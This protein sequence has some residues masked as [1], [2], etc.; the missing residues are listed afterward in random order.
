MKD[1]KQYFWWVAVYAAVST[2][3]MTLISYRTIS[4]VSQEAFLAMQMVGATLRF[5]PGIILG[6]FEFSLKP[7]SASSSVV[8]AWRTELRR[9]WLW[10]NRNAVLWT[11]LVLMS[12]L[13]A[14]MFIADQD[15]PETL[16]WRWV[17]AGAF[18]AASGAIMQQISAMAIDCISKDNDS[19]CVTIKCH[20]GVFIPA[21]EISGHL[22]GFTLFGILKLDVSLAWVYLSMPIALSI[23]TYK[24]VKWYSKL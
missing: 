4:A 10:R 6:G 8:G 18:N 9:E 15:N 24:E 23:M 21:G 2:A 14:F 5:I 16:V 3:V 11:D 13:T 1:M 12:G 7:P 17:L 19:A 22:I 20:E